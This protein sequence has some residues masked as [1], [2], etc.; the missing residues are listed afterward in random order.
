[1]QILILNI[2]SKLWKYI[3]AYI[4]W[5]FSFIIII[6]NFFPGASSTGYAMPFITIEENHNNP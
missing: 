2:E 4:F 5:I 6:M 3:K 1:M